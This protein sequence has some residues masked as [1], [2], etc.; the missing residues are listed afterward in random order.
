MKHTKRN[1]V[2]CILGGMG[3]Q[4]SARLLT[5]VVDKRAQQEAE[6]N[7]DFPEIIVDSVPT[8]DFISSTRNKHQALVMLKERVKTL[9][10]FSPT[11]F[12]IACN[13]AHIFL[14]DLSS[15]TGADFVSLI[16][17]VSLRVAEKGIKR[18][19]LLA[20]LVTI[21]SAL[22]QKE[23]A[24]LNIEVVSPDQK[25]LEAI[26]RIIRRILSGRNRKSDATALF[27]IALSLRTRGAEGIILGCTEIPLVFPKKFP[28]PTF[29]SIDI[30]ADALLRGSGKR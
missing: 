8:P 4:A 12:G 10:F 6:L 26:E 15:L 17:E 27:N 19:G 21:R 2:I 1:Q 20:T 24:E 13:T 7:S 29:D 22:Y 16:R 28:L 9:D 3:P 23:L 5:V 14:K 11:M 18:V 25:E 30:L